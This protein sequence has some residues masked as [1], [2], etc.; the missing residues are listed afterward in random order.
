MGTRRSREEKIK[1]PTQHIKPKFR[2]S[3]LPPI[4]VLNITMKSCFRRVSKFA[5]SEY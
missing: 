2:R 5:K 3:L 4:H 1:V